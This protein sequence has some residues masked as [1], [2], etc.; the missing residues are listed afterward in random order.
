MIRAVVAALIL[1]G[2]TAPVAHGFPGDPMPGC[3]TNGLGGAYCDGPIR[4][5]GTFQRCIY[6]SGS[7]IGG[8]WPSYL[9][10]TTN[11]MIIDNNN[12]PAFPPWVPNHHIDS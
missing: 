5:D 11:C 12:W 2:F 9:P 4:P 6:T 3:E 10:P 1:A 8:R 7:Y